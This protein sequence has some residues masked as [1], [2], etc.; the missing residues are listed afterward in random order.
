MRAVQSGLD[1]VKRFLSFA[2][3]FD[4]IFIGLTL[5]ILGDYVGFYHL[6]YL[7]LIPL[8]TFW[9]ILVAIQAF[10]WMPAWAFRPLV[11]GI[12]LFLLGGFLVVNFLVPKGMEKCPGV[13]DT[14]L[15]ERDLHRKY[16][17][18]KV[19][20]TPDPESGNAAMLAKSRKTGREVV[21]KL[22]SHP[23]ARANVL[24]V[25]EATGQKKN[26]AAKEMVKLLDAGLVKSQR[27]PAMFS[28]QTAPVGQPVDMWM[29]TGPGSKSRVKVAQGLADK[30]VALNSSFICMDSISP[31]KLFVSSDGVVHQMDTDV[32]HLTNY[33]KVGEYILEC[34][35][36]SAEMPARLSDMARDR[37]DDGQLDTLTNWWIFMNSEKAGR[38]PS[39][40]VDMAATIFVINRNYGIL[41]A[42]A[43]APDAE[44]PSITWS[45]VKKAAA[46]YTAGDYTSVLPSSGVVMSYSGQMGRLLVEGRPRYGSVVVAPSAEADM[47]GVAADFEDSQQMPQRDFIFTT[48]APV[49]VTKKVNADL[50]VT[51][52]ILS[53][54]S[55]N[56]KVYPGAHVRMTCSNPISVSVTGLELEVITFSVQPADGFGFKYE[57]EG[58]GVVNG[59]ASEFAIQDAMMNRDPNATFSGNRITEMVVAAF[60]LDDVGIVDFLS[61]IGGSFGLLVK[62]TRTPGGAPGTTTASQ[63]SYDVSN[64]TAIIVDLL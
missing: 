3:L 29:A 55:I 35:R 61:N 15:A 30:A 36:T 44:E 47:L 14:A 10:F 37:L 24:S 38:F 19:I 5:A 27:G 50:E 45:K 6:P 12:G 33:D 59:G 63:F 48:T 41:A 8:I 39:W 57:I 60:A 17:I 52:N 34:Q 7:A 43:Q 26:L 32:G 64:P 46:E 40:Q 18:S 4:S 23:N 16:H 31:S 25:C 22:F 9:F 2:P 49:V 1:S 51:L 11:L 13:A 62:R 21:I 56:L 28:V 53:S 58:K 20:Q 54:T 42:L